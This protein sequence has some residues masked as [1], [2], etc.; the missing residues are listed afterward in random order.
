MYLRS[1]LTDSKLQVLLHSLLPRP[2][3]VL[4]ALPTG[5]NNSHFCVK[6]VALIK[7]ERRCPQG[8]TSGG[9]SKDAAI[10]TQPPLR[11]LLKQGNGHL[12]YLKLQLQGSRVKICLSVN[13]P[14]DPFLFTECSLIKVIDFP[15]GSAHSA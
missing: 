8:E 9:G 2:H 11:P 10:G 6:G 13:F 1:A 5:S 15:A 12:L 7:S 14:F 3:D 4:L